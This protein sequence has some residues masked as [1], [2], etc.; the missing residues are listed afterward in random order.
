MKERDKLVEMFRVLPVQAQALKRLQISTA[1]DL[2]YYFPTRYGDT[3]EVMPIAGLT[4]GMDATAFGKITGLKTSKAFRKKIPMSEA[5]L[6][7]ESGKIK[8]VWFNQPYLAKMIAEGASVRVEGK[9]A[10]RKEE[11]YFSNPK[12]ESLSKL[13]IAVGNSLF[14]KDGEAHFLYPVYPET[15]GLTSNWIF[16]KLQNIFSSGLLDTL[17]DPIPEEILKRYSLPAL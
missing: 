9:V 2:L 13:P 10:S 1:E 17:V 12:I 8:I 14:G 7:D 16:H 3:A 15:R 11:V 6:E 4:K 5:W